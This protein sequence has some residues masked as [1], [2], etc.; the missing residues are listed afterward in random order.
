MNQQERKN[1]EE[2]V[3]DTKELIALYLSKWYWFIISVVVCCG[4]AYA[5]LLKTPTVYTRTASILIKTDTQGKS[6]ASDME[7]SFNNLGLF[8]S[9]TNIENEMVNFKS[10]NLMFEVVRNLNLEVRYATEGRFHDVVLYGDQLPFR[11]EFTDLENPDYSSFTAT[12]SK[13]NKHIKLSDFVLNGEELGKKDLIVKIG[14]TVKTPVGKLVIKE[15]VYPQSTPFVG[16]VFVTRA[17][18]YHV[19]DSYCDRLNVELENKN[20]TVIRLSFSDQNVQRA[21]EVLNTIIK[22]Y[23]ENWIKDRNQICNSTNKFINE[24]LKVIQEELGDVDDKITEFKSANMIPDAA[25]A[26]NIDMQQAARQNN[27]IMSLSNQLSIARYLSN[28]ISSSRNQLLPANAGLENQSIMQ[29][30]NQYN[31]LQLQRNR[32]VESSSE[33]NLLVQDI[34]KQ[35][36]SLRYTV[37]STLENYIAALN[38]Q[39][40]TSQTAK[41]QATSRIASSPVQAGQLLSSERQQKVKEALYL[42]LLQKREENELSQ[43]FT[44]YNTS[45]IATPDHGNSTLKTTPDHTKVLLIAFL[46]GLAIPLLLFYTLEKMKTTVRSRKDLANIAVPLFGEIPLAYRKK[47][48]FITRLFKRDKQKEGKSEVVVKHKGRDIVNEAFRILRTN[49]EFMNMKSTTE[50][51]HVVMVVSANPGSGKTFISANLATTMAI[52]GHRTI[53]I[54][55][56]I[57]RKALSMYVDKTKIGISDYLSEKVKDYKDIILPKETNGLAIDLIPCGTVPPNPAELIASPLLAKLIEDLRKQYDYIFLD[58]PPVGIVTDAD[59]IAPNADTTLFA[60]RVGL[61][62]RSMLGEIEDL[63]NSHRCK[64]MGIILNGTE[65]D[66]IYGHKYGYKSGYGYSGYSYFS[67]KSD[68]AE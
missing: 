23:N 10:P 39:L 40:H 59:L 20:T 48:N 57:R 26:I 54:D 34:D 24:R 47:Q 42:F 12:L 56:D 3:L 64:N 8:T 37:L 29:L 35:L 50:G 67:S 4:L 45:V 61:F 55:L 27:E 19:A 15:P 32:H 11:V 25:S 44:S 7:N 17:N 63:Y 41:A 21:E 31:E 51:A 9:N 43:T 6:L 16:K 13:D 46:A 2:N 30:I 65:S 52:K 1:N 28:Y 14:D 5:Y 36:E 68:S 18:P 49:L 60:I 62:E 22:V 58:C 33:E 66:G 38:T 53:A